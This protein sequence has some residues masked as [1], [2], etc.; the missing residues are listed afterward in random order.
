MGAHNFSYHFLGGLHEAQWRRPV[1]CCVLLLQ[2]FVGLLI[3]QAELVLGVPN[4]Q[5]LNY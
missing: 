3:V 1:L 2:R 5:L 4:T